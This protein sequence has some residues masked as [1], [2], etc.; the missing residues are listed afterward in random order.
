MPGLPV[1]G[2]PCGRPPFWCHPGSHGGGLH[3]A[4]E[5]SSSECWSG[6]PSLPGVLWLSVEIL[7]LAKPLSG[8][9]AWASGSLQ[10]P[11]RRERVQN[12]R[13][14]LRRGSRVGGHGAHVD[15]YPCHRAVP[16][17]TGPGKGLRLPSS[18][19]RMP[20]GPR[21]LALSFS[22][23]SCPRRVRVCALLPLLPGHSLRESGPFPGTQRKSPQDPE[24]TPHLL[25]HRQHSERRGF[26]WILWGKGAF[27]SFTKHT[28]QETVSFPSKD[29][30]HCTK[31]AS[32]ASSWTIHSNC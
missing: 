25:T 2:W 9:S 28:I 12:P 19:A 26:T 20:L 30:L 16:A 3:T 7:W 15:R 18:W 8:H 4:G 29:F 11:L 5:W 31:S 24:V 27:F 1:A 22:P 14:L 13:E 10:V 32:L 17:C 23:S 6:Q 21:L